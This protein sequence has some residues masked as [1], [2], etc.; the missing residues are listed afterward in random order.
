MS[1][2]LKLVCHLLMALR[3]L[4]MV[5]FA[6]P[7]TYNNSVSVHNNQSMQFCRTTPATNQLPVFIVFSNNV[8]IF[9]HDAETVRLSVRK[10]TEK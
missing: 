4:M 1:N 7:S 5:T 3:I 10:N 9:K 2:V 8:H 6:R